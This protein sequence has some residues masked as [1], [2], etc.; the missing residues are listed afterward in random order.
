M[1]GHVI[2]NAMSGGGG[3]SHAEPA[4]QQQAAPQQ[5][6]QPQ[7]FSKPCEFELQQFLDCSKNSDLSM[8]ES[9]NNVLRDCRTRY[10]I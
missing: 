6:Y 3:S 5:V 1:Q 8:C 2:G 10:G 4:V 9:F 7:Q